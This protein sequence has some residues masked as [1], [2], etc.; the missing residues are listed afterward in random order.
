MEFDGAAPTDMTTLFATTSGL[1]WPPPLRPDTKYYW[2]LDL[3]QSDTTGGDPANTPNPT[4]PPNN[5]PG[6]NNIAGQ[7]EVTEELGVDLIAQLEL[8]SSC[9]SNVCTDTIELT[10][11]DFDDDT[12]AYVQVYSNSSP[13]ATA[14]G[15][16]LYQDNGGVD[17][18]SDAIP[19]NVTFEPKIPNEHLFNAGWQIQIPAGGGPAIP[20]PVRMEAVTVVGCKDTI[21]NDDP[22]AT[23]VN[24]VCTDCLDCPDY[25]GCTGGGTEPVT[26]PNPTQI[27]FDTA[28]E[29]L[30]FEE[31]VLPKCEIAP[32]LADVGQIVTV[33]ITD[34]PTDVDGLIEVTFGDLLLDDSTSTD[35][36]DAAG[37]VQVPVP[38]PD[39]SGQI[40]LSVGIQG[41]APRA[42]CPVT[43]TPNP[44]CPDND[45]DSV[46]DDVDPDDDND[47]VDDVDDNE[48][49]FRT[50]CR[51]TDGDGCDDCS[52]GTSNPADDGPDFDGDG[53][54]DS[55]D[56]DIDGDGVP[57]Q[58]DTDAEDPHRCADVDNDTCDDCSSGFN[59]PT[60]D[61]TDTDG[62][63]LC[64]EGDVDNDGDGVDDPLDSD[65]EN[66]FVCRD[67]DQ[68]TCDDCVSGTDAPNDDGTDT[69]SDG[70]CDDG[71]PDDDNDGVP[72]NEDSD[73]LDGNVCGID[74][75][76]D[77]CDDCSN[78]FVNPNDDGVDTDADGLCNPGDPDDDNDNVPD[79]ID[80][81]PLDRF[82]CYDSETPVQQ[83]RLFP[84]RGDM[85]DDCASGTVDS[86]NDGQDTDGDGLC[87]LG[88]G[89]DDND[90]LGDT[91]D[92]DPYNP[93][94]CGDGDGDGCEDC[95]SG[96]S[97]PFNDGADGDLDGICDAGDNCPAVANADQAD[98]DQNAIGD[99]CDALQL[100]VVP[101]IALLWPP[102]HEMVPVTLD[103]VAEHPQGTPQVTLI[104][105]A[106]SEPDDGAGDGQTVSDIQG[107]ALGLAD[108]ELD[109]RAERSRNGNGRVYTITYLATYG[110]ATHSVSATVSVPLEQEGVAEPVMLSLEETASGT[111]VSWTE[112]WDA[113]SYNVIR[114]DVGQLAD[115]SQ[116]I[117]LGEVVCVE[118]GSTDASTAGAEDAAM[119]GPGQVFFYL[120]EYDNGR[121][122]CYGTE[123]SS[124]P[125]TPG[126][127]ACD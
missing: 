113:T 89:D 121:A 90:G 110:S 24:C 108:F 23:P 25:P 127:G 99:A 11:F 124:K 126:S 70:L 84:E 106:S 52:S 41:F 91:I 78:G 20:H 116:R 29:E 97:D 49:L 96:V 101:S 73:S 63:G 42:E 105:V 15:I 118:A 21:F 37:S 35:E 120:V 79:E 112:V 77:S 100:T 72:D 104:S 60:D 83:S 38:L 117:D 30:P 65:P 36:I 122:S 2:Y 61:G 111:R 88:D 13:Q 74:S 80:G 22:T 123:T 7:P 33:L 125:R 18:E 44:L 85:C 102:N 98:S 75:D 86:T 66:R 40:N 12:G 95:A 115:V 81:D 94:V 1:P 5:F 57:N 46:C 51:D 27:I 114:G 17:V 107:A 76:G 48:P 3:D 14:I 31:V 4:D 64:D 56:D 16:G 69:D 87:D 28:V 53:L 55:G 8:T 58:D 47:G 6:A 59:D 93:N 103:V 34:L 45:G 92:D 26:L 82:V 67:V 19:A 32:Q 54:C 68:D 43:V 50:I 9:P 71:D 39:A 10:V 62:D 119:P 109:L